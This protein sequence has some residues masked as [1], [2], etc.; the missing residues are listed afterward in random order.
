M[1]HGHKQK[2]RRRF[3]KKLVSPRRK[4]TLNTKQEIIDSYFKW[5]TTGLKKKI[6]C[7]PGISILWIKS[8]TLKY[9]Q[10]EEDLEVVRSKIS[11]Y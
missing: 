5:A 10:G 1:W 3:S 2:R 4:I 8:N 9:V 7:L 11:K 6:P